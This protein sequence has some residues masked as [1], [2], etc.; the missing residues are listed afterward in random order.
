LTAQ[1][2][3]VPKLLGSEFSAIWTNKTFPKLSLSSTKS[4]TNL[5]D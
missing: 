3:R 2:I 5:A 1:T 4:R